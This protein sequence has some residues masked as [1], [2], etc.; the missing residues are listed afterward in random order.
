[1]LAQELFDALDKRSTYRGAVVGL[2]SEPV[3]VKSVSGW[4]NPPAVLVMETVTLIWSGE[5]T[6]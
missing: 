5:N 4:E 2:T 6:Q 1:M 3:T